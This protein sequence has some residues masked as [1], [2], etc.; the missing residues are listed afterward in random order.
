MATQT[1]IFG[2]PARIPAETATRSRQSGPPLGRVRIERLI[3]HELDNHHGRL[4][5]VDEPVVLSEEA[6]EYFALYVEEAAARADWRAQFAGTDG[7]VPDLCAALLGGPGDFVAASRGLAERLFAQM[8]PRTIAPGDFAIAVYT[9][10]DTPVR[11]VALLKL[12]PDHRLAR[13]FTRAG[14]KTRVTI[15]VAANILPSTKRLQKCALLTVP[16]PGAGFDITLLDMQAGPNADGVAAFFYRGF[17]GAELSPSPRRRTREFLRYCDAWMSQQRDQLTPADL[18]TFYQARRGALAAATLDCA[19][20][21]TAALPHHPHLRDNLEAQLAPLIAPADDAT[22]AGA[23]AVDPVVA[24]PV[25][26][27]VTYELDGGARLSVPADRFAELVR[28]EPERT[29]ENKYRLVVESLTLKE[30][31]DR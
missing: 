19:T 3:L 29:A 12:D 20:F 5:L 4:R 21:V 13:E 9:W 15:G 14:M 22:Q 25:V 26:A 24:A 6:A 27:R 10:G 1:A 28:I 2:A 8:R 11:H 23:F 30:V 18:I 7:A 31:S 16:A 17:L